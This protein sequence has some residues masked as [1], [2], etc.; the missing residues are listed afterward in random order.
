MV[1]KMDKFDDRHP[2]PVLELI[3]DLIFGGAQTGLLHFLEHIDRQVFAPRVAFLRNGNTRVADQIRSLN[4]PVIDLKIDPKIRLD[5]TL[6]LYQL[7]K[8]D[9]IVILHTW[10]FHANL[11]GRLTGS[12]AQ[13]PVIISSRHN[14]DIGGWWRE[15]INRWTAPLDDHTIAVCQ[16]V[17]SIEIERSKIPEN[18]VSTI[19]NGVDLN[20]FEHLDPSISLSVRMEL[21]I[22]SNAPTIGCVGRLHQQKGYPFLLEAIKTVRNQIP[23]IQLLI[24]GSGKMEIELKSIVKKLDLSDSVTFTG[25]RTDIPAIL[26]SLDLFVLPSLW[27]GHPLVLLEAMATGLPVVATQVGGNPE[28]VIHGETGLMVPPSNPVQLASAIITLMQNPDLRH[29]MGEAG[30]QRSGL[31]SIESM[32]RKIE[33]LYFNLYVQKFSPKIL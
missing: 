5:R 1:T 11:L 20:R 24:V 17:R 31:F 29:K 7:I 9:R 32:T 15:S 10:L 18:K 3:T 4:I 22:P 28:V 26:S 27:E 8:Q 2:I 6:S 14:I 33:A 12:F 19:Y 16:F 30:R 21:G 25:A 13:V 23:D